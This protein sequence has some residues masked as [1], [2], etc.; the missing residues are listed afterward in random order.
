VY[1]CEKRLKLAQISQNLQN[2]SSP[3]IHFDRHNVGTINLT[4]V[5][6]SPKGHCYGNRSIS[7]AKNWYQLIPPLFF[8]HA[9]H[10]K[11]E[12]RHLNAHISS[13]DDGITSCKNLANFP[14]AT[15]KMTGLVCVFVLVSECEC[16]KSRWGGRLCSYRCT[17]RK[18]ASPPL[19]VALSFWN[20]LEYR[21]FDS[22]TLIGNYMSASCELLVRFGSVTAEFKM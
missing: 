6:R 15:S 2:R 20:G 14:P 11:L 18:T 17:Q 7:G 4:F 12:Y 9:F 5:L 22:L 1:H 8:S 3:N 16:D 21:N 13:W 19:F 10:N